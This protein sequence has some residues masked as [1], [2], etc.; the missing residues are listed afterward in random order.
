MK[1]LVEKN[2]EFFGKAGCCC[3]VLLLALLVFGII[4]NVAQ[5]SDGILIITVALGC[6]GIWVLAFLISRLG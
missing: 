3:I 1:N 4:R 2:T 6:L 5:I